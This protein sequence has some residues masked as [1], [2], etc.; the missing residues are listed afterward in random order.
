MLAAVDGPLPIDAPAAVTI[1]CNTPTPGSGDTGSVRSSSRS[2]RRRRTSSRSP[3]TAR[4]ELRI[5]TF[6][7]GG[8][9][10][11][12][13]TTQGATLDTDTTGTIGVIATAEGVL[14]TSSYANGT[15]LYPLHFDGTPSGLPAVNAAAAA[16]GSLA[17]SGIDGTLAFVTY[18]GSGEI[19]AQ[20]IDATGAPSGSPQMIIPGALGAGTIVSAPAAT[21]YVVTWTDPSVTPH[22][23]ELEL[24]G[25]SICPWLTGPVT[26]KARIR[27][28]PRSARWRGRR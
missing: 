12:M 22:A 4:K 13:P 25:P 24:L 16:T 26:A 18:G 20:L 15:K 1:A 27:T 9:G 10:S 14:V 5:W 2:P 21:G 11:L 19:D 7:I 8:D 3:P 23:T 6:D 17:A 28:A